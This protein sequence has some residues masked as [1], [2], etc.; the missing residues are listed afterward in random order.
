MA[1]FGVRIS[2]SQPGDF[3]QP[4]KSPAVEVIRKQNKGKTKLK[5]ITLLDKHGTLQLPAFRF[6]LDLLAAGFF[7]GSS[8]TAL[9]FASESSFCIFFS[10]SNAV[11]PA[12]S[13]DPLSYD[14]SY[15][16]I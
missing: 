14:K 7:W 16:Y 13:A 15:I 2:D 8:S 5:Y 6:V 4:E 9:S 11:K 1:G 3:L 10:L 12:F